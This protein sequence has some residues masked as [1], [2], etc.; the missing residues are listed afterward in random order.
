MRLCGIY[1]ACQILLQTWGIQI[2][3]NLADVITDGPSARKLTNRRWPQR[4]PGL[5]HAY[6]R[7]CTKYVPWLPRAQSRIPI[8]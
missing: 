4:W 8:S 5:R 6:Y 1:T 7:E 2:P 3:E